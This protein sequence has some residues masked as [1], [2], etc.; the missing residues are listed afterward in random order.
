MVQHTAVLFAASNLILVREVGD[1]SAKRN[2]HYAQ[3]HEDTQHEFCAEVH[4]N[5][6]ENQDGKGCTDKIGDYRE[7]FSIVSKVVPSDKTH[8]RLGETCLPVQ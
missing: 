4:L 5:L 7:D 1:G 2:I 8:A 3:A 6:A